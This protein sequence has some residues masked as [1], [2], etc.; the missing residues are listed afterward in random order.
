MYGLN[1][2]HPCCSLVYGMVGNNTL[3]LLSR[4]GTQ[5]FVLDLSGT[6][7][8]LVAWASECDHGILGP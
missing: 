2:K 8:G 1:K 4:N 3:N 7:Y 5:A 6:G